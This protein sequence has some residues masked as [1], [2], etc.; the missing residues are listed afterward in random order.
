[1]VLEPKLNTEA[2][3]AFL[4][5]S[6][7]TQEEITARMA[8]M[9]TQLKKNAQFFGKALEDDKEA[10]AQAEALLEKNMATTQKERGRLGAYSGKS[11][12]TTWLVFLS[13]AVVGVAWVLMFFLIR[14][15]NIV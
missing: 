3:S 2:T 8:E 12:G 4:T 13:V 7:Q 10:I 11:R 15:T 14:I 6:R 5:T 9:A 1:M